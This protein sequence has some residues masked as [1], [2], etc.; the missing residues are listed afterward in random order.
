MRGA[1]GI[2]PSLG[3]YFA[4]KQELAD[5]GCMSRPH[6]D[7]CLSGRKEFTDQ[8]KKAI[9]RAAIIKLMSGDLRYVGLYDHTKLEKAL[10]GHFD[11]EFKVTKGEERWLKSLQ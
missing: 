7:D 6:L 5:A 1:C 4:T 3:R 8:Q 11:E 9:T 10:N 2:Y